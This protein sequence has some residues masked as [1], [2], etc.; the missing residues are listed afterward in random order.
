MLTCRQNRLELATLM[1]QKEEATQAL[2]A[3]TAEVQKRR[4]DLAA[5]N[6]RD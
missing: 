2:H 6:V 4:A 3:A 5:L 1:S